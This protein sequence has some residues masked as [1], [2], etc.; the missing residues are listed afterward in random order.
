[1]NCSWDCGRIY[2]AN[3]TALYSQPLIS[4]SDIVAYAK[5]YLG[6]PYV[7][8][9]SDPSVGFDC[10]G[11]VWYVCK[12]FGIDLG[13][14]NLSTQSSHGT[15]VPY[16]TSS[17]AG[18]IENMLPG[19]L[20]FFDYIGST[21]QKED[22]VGIYVGSGVV[23]HAAAG[24]VI[25]T[26]LNQRGWPYPSDNYCLYQH[27]CGIRRVIADA[28]VSQVVS[29]ASTPTVKEY[30]GHTYMYF[31]DAFTWEQANNFCVQMGGHLVT[32]TN[33]GENDLVRSLIG[34][35]AWIGCTRSSSTGS[36]IWKTGETFSYANWISGVGSENYA[37]ILTSGEWDDRLGDNAEGFVCEF[38]Q[39]FSPV[40]ST[41][42]GNITYLLFDVSIP[43]TAAEAVCEMKGGHLVT[44]CSSSEQAIVKQLI[45]N[46]SKNFYSIGF[47]DKEKE[48]TWKWITGEAASYENW[49]KSLPEPNGGGKE[50][51]AV[52]MAVDAPPN[53]VIGEWV[54]N[55]NI[56]DGFT[57]SV[58]ALPKSGFVC[59]IDQLEPVTYV[60]ITAG[61]YRLKNGSS[62][63][64]AT[65][66][67][68]SSTPL[69]VSA[70]TDQ[71]SQIFNIFSHP[72]YEQAYMMKPLSN[73]N[74]RVNVWT[75]GNS[76]NGSA[77]TLYRNTE[78]GSQTWV[79]EKK[80]DAY[81]I[82]PYDNT[83][84]S[85]TNTNGS[86]YVKTTTGDSSQLWYLEGSISITTQPKSVS[87]AEGGTATF[88]V[89]ANGATSYQ[90]QWRNGSSGTWADS[91]SATT[92]YNT[93]TL[94]VSATAARNGYQY[95]CKVSNSM[96]TTISGIA[97]LTVESKPAIT[98]QPKSV[99]VA[100]GGT[101]AFTVAAT[102]ATSYQW[103]WRNGSSGTWADS[104]SA[105]TGYNTKT[106]KVSATAVRNGYQY[107]CKVSNSAG[108][109]YTNIVTLTVVSKPAITT[110][111]KS[112]SAA[113]GG[114]ATFTVAA[115]GATSYQWQWR[116]GSSGTWTDST[117]ATTGYNTKTLKVSATAARSGYQYRCK[118]S[119]SS[120]TTYTNIA[121][122]TVLSKPAIT[123]QPK[124]VSVAE[125]G[126]ATFTVAATGA[127]SYLWQWRDGSS[128]T[129]VDCTSATT[130]YNT[131]TL[132]VSAASHR[133]GYQYRCKVSNSAGTTYS[134]TVTLTVK[135]S[136]IPSITKQPKSVI[137]GEG[138]TAAF[139]VAATGATSYLWQWRN[140]SS[141]TWA[142]CTSATT[143]YNTATLKVSAASH[144]NGY[145]YRCLVSNASGEVYTNVVSLTVN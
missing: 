9:G 39:I 18:A 69:S 139:T 71:D 28:H 124:S 98:T 56:H 77:V 34:D 24:S 25:E 41:E 115:T 60:T 14:I 113:E 95:R 58:Y 68:D 6:V 33:S 32:I 53:K 116:N 80:G 127:T 74:G 82:H 72:S 20:V 92:G 62:Y 61:N 103:Q 118:V 123:T 106:L 76:T 145:Q 125:G 142:D 65:T 99:S 15:S 67:L 88:T 55:T 29:I 42:N 107:R 101:A 138:G 35:R 22:H 136:T 38:D 4:G 66:Q 89:A 117:S 44:I 79:F 81:L 27:I 45:Q 1:M 52:I 135:S 13:S 73:T 10:G 143:G 43:W 75:S 94:K 54:D 63:L 104:T 30:N 70:L 19:D 114:T 130:G 16:S 21:G 23:I 5:N 97:T 140:G 126:T 87:V 8:G 36:W 90:W 132:K 105:T 12:H 111:P 85:L 49:D 86:T 129:W 57:D 47:T 120:G 26:P 50:N 83:S 78:H 84:L 122:L 31:A 133:N 51:Y 11:F 134:G 96:G 37:D 2:Y 137:V 100:E 64:S 144:R 7:S 112:V 40:K 119:N 46:G 131:A 141:G 121:T 91:T 109:T 93:K 48:G 59:E 102:G 128:G 108:T 17:Y 110:Q 3:I